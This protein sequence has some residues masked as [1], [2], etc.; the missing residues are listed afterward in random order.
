MSAVLI[1]LAVFFC[2]VLVQALFAGYET[3]FVSTNP[4]RIRFMAEEEHIPRASRLMAYIGRPDR[5]LIVLLIGT[6]V[7][8]VVG[9]IAISRGATILSEAAGISRHV[10]DLLVTLVATPVFL[11]FAE[12]IPKSVFRTHP[13]RLSLALLPVIHAVYTILTPLAAPIA[14]VIRFLFRTGSGQRH[15][16]SPLMT[17]RDDV[18]VL[19]DESA[20]HGTIEP[21]EQ[22]MIHRV[23]NLQSKQA[24]E[25]MVPRIDIQALPDTATREELLALFRDTGRTRIPIY[26][27]TIDTVIGVINAHDVLLD[28]DPG[29]QD[30]TRFVREVLH[31]PDTVK[32]DDLFEQLKKTKQHMAMVTD[33]YG[34]T[35]GLITIEDILEEIFG[36]IQD[37]HDREESPIT[38]AGPDAYV[39]D[40]RMP[41]EDMAQSI[42]IPLR[43]H[44]IETVGGWLMHVA[45]RIP[46]Q[47]EVI[48]HDGLRMTVLDGG[49]NY[50]AKI[51]LDVLP[52]ARHG[53]GAHD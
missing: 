3:G 1:A 14:A 10:N 49:P 34:G 38:Q 46:A 23:I 22:R 35:D 15:Y 41:L 47:G 9:T 44:E 19:V 6:N 11:V 13:N 12:I 51:R 37:E 52:E 31:V 8:T 16:L 28:A 24:K 33:E 21:Q 26:A 53:E 40:A 18:R 17:T 7:A 36:E 42:G 2:A 39:I 48:L 4:I 25:I 30:I 43:D 32:V 29:Q 20:D 5:M 45:G 50:V 27:D